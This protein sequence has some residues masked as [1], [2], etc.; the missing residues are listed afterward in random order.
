[1]VRRS[2]VAALLFLGVAAR[3]RAQG[4]IPS[5]SHVSP[6][7]GTIAPPPAS[8]GSPLLA[9]SGEPTGD[10]GKLVGYFAS[11]PLRLS[12]QIQVF[13]IGALFDGCGT[14]SDAAGNVTGEIPAQHYALLRLTPNLVLHGFS[15]GGCPIDGAIGGGITYSAPIKPSLWLVAGAGLYSTPAQLRGATVVHS[16]FRLDLVKKINDTRS[17]SV[18]VGRHGLSFGGAF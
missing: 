14:R 17:L 11:A 12:L 10:P 4:P 18:G 15:A 16:D 8:G 3:A 7:F 1:M 9:L 2:L 6:P 13:P 5:S